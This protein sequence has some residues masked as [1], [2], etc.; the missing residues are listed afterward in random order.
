MTLGAALSR[1]YSRDDRP[2]MPGPVLQAWSYLAALHEA[3]A[4]EDMV[5][6]ESPMLAGALL[7]LLRY[8]T[9]DPYAS[10]FHESGRWAFRWAP[11]C[12]MY[13]ATEIGSL[14]EEL[15]DRAEKAPPVPPESP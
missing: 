6:W 5:K 15:I 8:L 11:G 3:G 12:E 14:V 13:D 4:L 10:T 9:G 2:G 1:L 7:A